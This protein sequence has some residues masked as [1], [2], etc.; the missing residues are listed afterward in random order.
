MS[1]PIGFPGTT[2]SSLPPG[3]NVGPQ[4]TLPPTQASPLKLAWKIHRVCTPHNLEKTTRIVTFKGTYPLG[5]FPPKSPP[6]LSDDFRTPRQTGEAIR[7]FMKK[8]PMPH[9]PTNPSTAL[10]RRVRFHPQVS[11][12][13]FG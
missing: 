6:P 1:T 13:V 7:N 10:D 4:P 2:P 11:I 5:E 3:H 9:S 12:R 8:G